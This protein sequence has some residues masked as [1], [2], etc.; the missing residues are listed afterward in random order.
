MKLHNSLTGRVEEFVPVHE[1]EVRMYNCGP[2]VYKRQ[3]LGNF[4]AF[5]LADLLRRSFEFLGYR[6][7]QIMNITDVGHLTEDDVADA[8]GEDKLQSEAAKRRLDPWEI[9]REEEENFREDLATLRIRPAKRY[10]RATDHVPEMI[11]MIE[12]LIEKGNAYPSEGNVYFDVSSFPSYG[13]LSGNT[14]DALS[15]GASGRVEVRDDKHS[16]NDFAL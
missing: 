11:E 4:R 1:G 15:E 5:I 14:T 6:V 10:P 16:P 13:A 2:T 8:Q 3:H 9:A 7:T 12:T